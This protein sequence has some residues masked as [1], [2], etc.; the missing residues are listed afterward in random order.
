MRWWIILVVVIVGFLV[1]AYF[2]APPGN[3]GEVGAAAAPAPGQS[4]LPE[5]APHVISLA[6]GALAIV[7][8]FKKSDNNA[9]L[10][11]ALAVLATLFGRYVGPLVLPDF[12]RP[13]V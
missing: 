1:G 10:L 8:V 9:I 3:I 12:L 2:L 13:P 6:F 5:W 7:L 11:F 4:G